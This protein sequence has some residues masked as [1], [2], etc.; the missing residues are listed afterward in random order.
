MHTI[1]EKRKQEEKE[2]PGLLLGVVEEKVYSR[3]VEEHSERQ[4]HL[5]H[6]TV[7]ITRLSLAMWGEGKG[8]GERGT[9]YSS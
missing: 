7:D 5:D 3:Y 4:G 9:R 6:S 2:R 1:N 8:K